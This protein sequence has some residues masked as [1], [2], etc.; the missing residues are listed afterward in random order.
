MKKRILSVLL[1]LFL[2]FGAAF[3]LAGRVGAFG[4]Y[5]GDYDF[6]GGWDDYDYDNDYDYDD[7]DYDYNYGGNDG[8]Y[9]GG[10]SGGS[11]SSGGGSGF[12][13]ALIFVAIIAAIIILANRKKKGGGQRPQQRPVDAGAKP[14][15]A[16]T[17]KPVQE[18]LKLD[19][20]FSEAQFKEKL[21]NLFVQFQNGWQDKDLEPLRPYMSDAYF[22]Q[23]DRQLDA[24]RKNNRTKMIERI[25]VLGVELSG[26]KQ[27]NG[28]DVM[29][30]RLNTRFTTYTVDDRTG[31]LLNGSKT[32]EKFMDYEWQLIRTSGK[33]TVQG[34][35]V[36]VQNCPN[37]GAT[38]NINQT[39]KC[40]YCGSIITVDAYDWVVNGIKAISQRTVG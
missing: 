39:A 14:T 26:W 13:G 23:M 34:G 29:I 10:S 19:P 21:A 9:Y 37:C 16:A 1:A 3:S 20:T 2:V 22:A 12:I 30:A 6:G 5:D 35:G 33:T 24:Y 27:E 25:A 32:A 40:E 11:S 15:D 36:T 28:S 8:Y 4:D 38:V 17:L 18:Y 31:N 7:D